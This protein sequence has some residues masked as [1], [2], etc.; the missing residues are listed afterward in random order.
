ME[1]FF[2]VGR[3]QS[4]QV[5]LEGITVSYGGSQPFGATEHEYGVIGTTLGVNQTTTFTIPTKAI[6]HLVNGDINGF[7]LRT[8]ETSVMTGD[9]N[10]YNYARFV[11]KSNS[12]Y[13]PKLTITYA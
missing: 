7:M 4:V 5:S 13:R 12:S 1:P 6:T 8:G 3:N 2:R 10:S 11:G 9:D